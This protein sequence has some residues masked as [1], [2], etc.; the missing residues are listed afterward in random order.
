MLLTPEGQFRGSRL[1][2]LYIR[3]MAALGFFPYTCSRNLLNP[4]FS[5][6]LLLWDI[7]VQLFLFS[8]S[9][10]QVAKVFV[11]MLTTDVG[12]W[13]F[14][15]SLMFGSIAQTFI[16]LLM[17][18]NSRR[19][20]SL[21][22]ELPQVL[23]GNELEEEQKAYKHLD[24]IILALTCTPFIVFCIVLLSTTENLSIGEII[25]LI[26]YSTFVF[27]SLIISLLLLRRLHFLLVQQVL[28][29]VEDVV[30][31][32]SELDSD[33]LKDEESHLHTLEQKMRQV[34]I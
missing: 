15:I 27:M 2:C 21:L 10:M 5:V 28:N 34:S 31:T 18:M 13:A 9:Y 4:I 24:L 20:A 16:P 7:F 26:V 17:L 23:S 29:D 8:A 30:V 3:I 1:L 6:K 19:L 33:A 12:G 25:Y 14:T 11:K 32:C 22:K